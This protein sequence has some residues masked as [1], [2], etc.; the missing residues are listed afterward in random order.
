MPSKFNSVV[1]FYRLP[2][3]PFLTLITCMVLALWLL[4]GEG[5][6]SNLWKW[7]PPFVFFKKFGQYGRLFV[8][9]GLIVVS[10]IG[11]I[12]EWLNNV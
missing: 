10:L 12:K 8:I 9:I 6:N 7:L 5:V 2:F 11:L 3:I 4:F 1:D